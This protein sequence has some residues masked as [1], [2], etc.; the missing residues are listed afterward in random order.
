[1]V[2]EAE[3]TGP[4]DVNPSTVVAIYS[5]EHRPEFFFDPLRIV[6]YIF[7]IH[8][9]LRPFLRLPAFDTLFQNNLFYLQTRKLLCAFAY[10][11][12]NRKNLRSSTYRP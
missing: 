6:Y 1:M 2:A 11:Y 3:S 4:G 7:P 5:Q 9:D 10:P 8:F 12:E